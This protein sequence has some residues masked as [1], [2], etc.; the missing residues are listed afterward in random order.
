MSFELQTLVSNFSGNLRFETLE[1]IEYLV[2]PMVMLTEGVHTGEGGSGALYYSADEL[3]KVPDVW[4]HKPCV[5]YHPQINGKG[6]SACSPEVL[7]NRKVGMI[8]NTRWDAPKLRAEAWLNINRLPI[9]D[10]RILE[11]LEENKIMEVST[12]VFTDN[13]FQEGEWNGESYVALATNLRADHLA[14]LPDKVGACSIKDGAGLL[15]LNSGNLIQTLKEKGVIQSN[16]TSHGDTYRQIA[17]ALNARFGYE[18]WVEEVY[19]DFFVYS[20]VDTL[21]R[22][23]YTSGES[24]VTLSDETPQEVRRE[25]NFSPVQN[26]KKEDEMPNKKKVDALIAN[27]T[28]KWEEGDSTFLLTLTDEQLDKLEPVEVVE[29]PKDPEPIAETPKDPEPVVNQEVKPIL[30]MNE[31]LAQAPPEYR[32]VLETGLMTHNEK[33]K[34]LI[35]VILAN[36]ANRFTELQLNSKPIG[37]IQAIADLCRPTQN[38]QDYNG[39]PT[40]VGGGGSHVQNTQKVKEEPYV[41]PTMEWATA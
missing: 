19:S 32:D 41:A 36:E 26:E 23:G 1:G 33:K 6:V 4:N 30:T 15:Q 20:R 29:T 5:V 27:G 13:I 18:S 8:L 10:E 2:A 14:L 31:Y 40:F 17:D 3:S 9:V 11:F 25:V 35:D 24:G 34:E 22:L 7:N 28:S 37:E 16:E 39:S 21:Y 12:G 38:E